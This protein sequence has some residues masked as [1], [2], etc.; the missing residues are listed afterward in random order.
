MDGKLPCPHDLDI[1]MVSLLLQ[2]KLLPLEQAKSV[3]LFQS[4]WSEVC[5]VTVGRGSPCHIP[6]RQGPSRHLA[7]SFLSGLV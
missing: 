4:V 2:G 5:A 3:M 1:K 7:L 6:T